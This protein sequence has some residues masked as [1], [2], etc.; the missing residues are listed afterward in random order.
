[1]NT[2]LNIVI[3][4]FLAA[5]SLTSCA[6]IRNPDLTGLGDGT[7]RLSSSSLQWQLARSPLFSS[8]DDASKYVAALELG[9]HSDWRLPTEDELLDL[10][11]VFDFGNAKKGDIVEGIKGYYWVAEKDGTGYI[12]AWKD[13]DSCEITRSFNAGSRGGY[14]RA[15]RP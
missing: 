14:V 12:G 11:N 2:R 6:G 15:V 8:W 3:L 1:M 5:I 10:H 4:L 13:G 7:M 9:G